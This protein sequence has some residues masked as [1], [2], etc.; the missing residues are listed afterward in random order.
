M[1][2]D[3]RFCEMAF[4]AIKRKT[5]VLMKNGKD[6]FSGVLV[7]DQDRYFIVTASHCISDLR[8]SDILLISTFGNQGLNEKVSCIDVCMLTEK[9]SKS[10]DVFDTGAIEI[11]KAFADRLDCQWIIR[12]NITSLAA[13]PNSTVLA[14]G[15][16]VDLIRMDGDGSVYSHPTPFLF[17]SQVSG[18]YPQVS[19]NSTILNQ[20]FDLMVHYEKNNIWS[21]GKLIPELHPRGMSGCGI[22]S[23]PIPAKDEL[24][25]ASGIKLA[26]IQSGIIGEFLRAKKSE[27]VIRLLDKILGE[28]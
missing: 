18:K 7:E 13:T 16:P 3:T 24:W 14:L 1:E 25:D 11:S 27:L 17:I 6:G 23:V 12:T 19:S 28:A 15:F 2:S 21:D 8:K 22:F 20:A 9:D 5:C 26:G 10:T 4:E